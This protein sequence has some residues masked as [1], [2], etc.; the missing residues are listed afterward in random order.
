MGCRNQTQ[1]NQRSEVDSI[2]IR[3]NK[4]ENSQK[5]R[6]LE[7]KIVLLGDI[8]VGKTSIASRYCKNTFN[9]HHINTIGGAYLQ[10]KIVL[11]NGVSIKFHIWDT[12]GQERFRT[13][14]NLYYHDAQAA[15]LT[16]DVTNEES[17]KSLDYWINE[18][19]GKVET[20]NMIL[21]L[22]GNK[23]DV[24]DEERKVDMRKGMQVAEKYGMTFF[25]TSAKAGTGIVELFNEI[26]N[27]IYEFKKLEK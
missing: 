19:K 18:L 5:S 1:Q 17:L 20:D 22:A 6:T 25:E 21:I 11:S 7:A 16:Y 15:I 27:R 12:S 13:M 4:D 3:T 14:T 10:Q 23:C 8:S 26:G 9:E 2:K 24:S